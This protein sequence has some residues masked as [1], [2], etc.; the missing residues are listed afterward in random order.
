MEKYVNEELK[1]AVEIAKAGGLNVWT[2]KN[3]DETIGQIFFD[4]G[5]TFG[6][7][8]HD[9]VG[10]KYM[11]CHRA[12]RSNGTGFGLYSTS[13]TANLNDIERTLAYAPSWAMGKTIQKETMIEHITRDKVLT[14][15]QL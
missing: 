10:I 13:G 3:Q 15:R 1:K 6:S 5:E 9:F 12:D 7:A 8:H 2:F 4:N 14:W 11:T